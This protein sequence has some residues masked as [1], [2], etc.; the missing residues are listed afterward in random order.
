MEENKKIKINASK[1]PQKRK[2]SKKADAKPPAKRGRPP[3]NAQ[4]KVTSD[5]DADV[6]FCIICLGPMPLKLTKNNSIACIDCGREVHLK[7]AKITKS[8]FVCQNCESD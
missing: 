8:Y 3:K 4:K 2:I 6:D 5:D 1:T 7:C